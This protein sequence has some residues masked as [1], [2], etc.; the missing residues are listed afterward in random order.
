[1]TELFNP[2]KVQA[3]FAQAAQSYDSVA[4]MQSEAADQ[5]YERLLITKLEVGSVLDLGAG[6]GACVSR[7]A[8]LYPQARLLALDPA[9]EMLAVAKVK[10]P[11]IECLNACAESIPLEDNAV[12]LVISNMMLH[13]SLD[14][15][16][17]F[18]EVKRILKPGGL[19]LFSTLGPDTL[20]ELRQSWATVD[21]YNHVHHF[22][23]MHDL[24]DALLRVDF[25][26]PVMDMNVLTLRYR[27]LNT[28][29]K[30]FKALGARNLAEPRKRGLTTKNQ[31]QLMLAAYEQLKIEDSYPATYEMVFGSAWGSTPRLQQTELGETYVSLERIQKA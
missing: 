3:Q 30:D 18:A 14:I 24:G 25:T 4:L 23:D 29:F 12:D 26:D 19:F 7:V 5:L 2:S 20:I 8:S 21:D 10:C 11:N 28:L 16:Q 9:A 17:V 22:Y 27:D 6:T 31:Y 13:W 1:M 15:E